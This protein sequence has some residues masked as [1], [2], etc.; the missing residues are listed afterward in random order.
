[1]REQMVGLFQ[2]EESVAEAAQLLHVAGC[3]PEDLDLVRTGDVGQPELSG[4][5]PVHTRWEDRR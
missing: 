3:T 2:R 4:L 5:G 1:M